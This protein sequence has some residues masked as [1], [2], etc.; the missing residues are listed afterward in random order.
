[1]ARDKWFWPKLVFCPF[2]L[3]VVGINIY[4]LGACKIYAGESLARDYVL[5][6]VSR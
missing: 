1:M 3:L 4:L 6:R 2:I 5:K